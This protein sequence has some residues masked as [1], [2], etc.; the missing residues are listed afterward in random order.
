MAR[1]DGARLIGD[2]RELAG[3][4]RYRT[5]VHRPAFSDADL[6]ARHWLA[7]RMAEAGLDAGI[8]GIGNV[9]G[10]APGDGP[11]LL[12]GSHSDTQP[13][14]GW[15]DGAMGVVYGIELARAM[16]D[17]PGCRG[18]GVDVASWQDEEAHY[19][20]VLGSRSFAGFLDDAE[21]DRARHRDDG[22]PLRHAIA[23][24]GLAGTPR[25]RLDASRYCGYLEAH[26]EQGAVLELD[27]RRIGVVTAIVGILVY[28]VT[29][30]GERNHAGT[31]P[32]R[33]RKDAGVALTA[34]CNEVHRE[35]KALAGSVTVW[36]I[37]RIVLE[38]NAPSVVPG[39]AELLLQIRD[40][41]LA[42]MERLGAAAIGLAEGADRTGPCRIAI[43]RTS[44]TE[45]VAM[46]EPFQ[47]AIAAAA[48][49]RAGRDWMRLVSGAGHDAQILAR[50]MPA[51]MLF[52]PSIGGISHHYTED[53]AEDD[54]VL[55]CQTFADAAEAILRS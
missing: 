41:S 27:Q 29:F 20:N 32:M 26:I 7:R 4:G 36:T 55:G 53:T 16:R 25:A 13:Q 51:G 40:P 42:T 50:Q 12:V 43:E 33:M 19:A 54:L 48:E 8:D 21:I 52:V 15:L 3:F 22:T 11:R 37:G 2:L 28:R 47:A 14:G 44:C 6:A 10:R 5:G 49:R 39:R 46:H 24:A 38:P 18:I 35:F 45:P 34:F 1:I 23:R 30:V 31:T 17:D 9:I